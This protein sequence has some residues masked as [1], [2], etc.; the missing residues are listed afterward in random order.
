MGGALNLSVISREARPRNLLRKRGCTPDGHQSSRLFRGDFS[1]SVV[2]MTG[3]GFSVS[4]CHFERG[5]TEKSPE[6][7]STHSGW[8]SR[9]S[10][11]P[12]GFLLISRNDRVGLLAL[13]LALAVGSFR[14]PYTISGFHGFTFSLALFPWL[15]F[16]FPWL[17]FLPSPCPSC[18]CGEKN[19][20]QSRYLSGTKNAEKSPANQPHPP[21]H[22]RDY[23]QVEG[24]A[25]GC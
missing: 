12:G 10:L 18:L 3:W 19:A 25:C 8:S 2:E 14:N 7:K 21:D 4:C 11:V 24:V 23:P 9:Q 5:T 13:A 1:S 16:L 15:F 17:F 6:K 22:Y 20:P